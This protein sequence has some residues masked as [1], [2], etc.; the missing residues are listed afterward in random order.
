MIDTRSSLQQEIHVK[1]S[2]LAP[3]YLKISQTVFLE[4]ERSLGHNLSHFCLI[5]RILQRIQ[6]WETF[7]IKQSVLHSFEMYTIETKDFILKVS[8]AYWQE[9]G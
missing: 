4:T 8:V 1:Y 2:C 5:K 3:D 7:G 6:S 9:I